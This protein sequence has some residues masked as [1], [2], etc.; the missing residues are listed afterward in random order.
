MDHDKIRM[1]LSAFKDGELDEDL[2]DL[3]LQHLQSCDSCRE[4]LNEFD[5]IDSMLGGLPEI[6][7]PQTFA[8]DIIVKSRAEKSPCHWKLSFVR[9]VSDRFFLLV[10]SILQMFPGYMDQRTG[11]LD[12]FGDFPPHSLGHAYLSLIGR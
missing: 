11:F 10:D 3:I 1:N 7:V 4:E 6:S 9:R 5:K 12:E 8:S 2:K